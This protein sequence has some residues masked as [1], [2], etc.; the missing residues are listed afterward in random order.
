M[1]QHSVLRY[2]LNSDIESQIYH[3]SYYFI[4]YENNCHKAIKTQIDGVIDI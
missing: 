2:I 3:H 4:N 1:N